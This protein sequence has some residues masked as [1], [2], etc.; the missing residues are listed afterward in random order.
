MSISGNEIQGSAS[1]VGIARNIIAMAS[2]NHYAQIK[3]TNFSSVNALGG[4]CVAV[5]I[6]GGTIATTNDFY[7][8]TYSAIGHTTL[9]I[10]RK[11]AQANT[12]TTLGATVTQTINAGAL[13]ISYH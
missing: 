5:P 7:F 6:L 3:A 10:R 2:T 4:P 12:T 8:F 1:A 11:D 13:Q 9:S